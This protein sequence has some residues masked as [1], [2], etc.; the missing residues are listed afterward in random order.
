MR[1]Y[2][3]LCKKISLPTHSHSPEIAVCPVGWTLE[4]FKRN[5]V[6]D[7]LI[8]DDLFE[9]VFNDSISLI[10]YGPMVQNETG[11]WS[12]LNLD[13]EDYLDAFSGARVSDVAYVFQMIRGWAFTTCKLD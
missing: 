13:A 4:R 5:R 8:D 1:R 6:K 3:T 7:V 9:L 12:L 10:A 11:Q 2:G